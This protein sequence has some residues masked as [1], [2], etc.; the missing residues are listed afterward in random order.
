MRPHAERDC[1]QHL[2]AGSFL[3]STLWGTRFSLVSAYT[4][5]IFRKGYRDAES[6]S[7]VR[8]S[9]ER[10]GAATSTERGGPAVAGED[11]SCAASEG[12]HGQVEGGEAEELPPGCGDGQLTSR[13]PLFLAQH[14]E[15]YAR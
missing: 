11:C 10:L 5:A 6:S 8:G 1:F 15:R 9:A 4:Y 3:G 12:S 2:T 13:T 14:S 7:V